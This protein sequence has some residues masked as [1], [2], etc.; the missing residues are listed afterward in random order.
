MAPELASA[1][2][3]MFTHARAVRSATVTVCG[4]SGR[5]RSA[6]VCMM[7]SVRASVDGMDMAPL[8]PNG[9]DVNSQGWSEAE[10]LDRVVNK[11]V[12]T[13]LLFAPNGADVNSQGWSAA[14]PLD[15]VVNKSVKPRRGGRDGRPFGAWFIATEFTR[16]SAALHPWL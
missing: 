8:R 14:E 12:W 5:K 6:S 16:G 11:S 7:T 15:R 10:P 9:A 3:W 2:V 13:W 1:A 4:P